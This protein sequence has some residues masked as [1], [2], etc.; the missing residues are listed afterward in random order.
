V[1]Q[2]YF[3]NRHPDYIYNTKKLRMYS[4][5][6][7][8]NCENEVANADFNYKSYLN[9]NE[10]NND[11]SNDLE[12]NEQNYD[13][14]VT[15]N[16]NNNYNNNLNNNNFNNNVNIKEKEDE[17]ENDFS[18]LQNFSD[19]KDIKKRPS[20]AMFSISSKISLKNHIERIKSK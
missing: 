10:K 5:K 14:L 15:F 19:N 2:E 1:L 13:A 7:R 16:A 8:L 12:N 18:N 3:S 20:T 6:T 9:L 4:C 11:I 17:N